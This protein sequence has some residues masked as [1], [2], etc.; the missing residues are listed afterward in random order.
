MNEAIK[1][2]EN[3]SILK[4]ENM[5]LSNSWDEINN[6]YCVEMSLRHSCGLNQ[7]VG[8]IYGRLKN[9]TFGWQVVDAE[10]NA[11]VIL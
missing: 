8:M 11:I 3:I 2:P 5:V 6:C 1:A 9:G 10:D 4:G 7:F